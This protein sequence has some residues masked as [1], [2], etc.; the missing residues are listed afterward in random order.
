VL[1]Q[2]HSA[3]KYS[4]QILFVVHSQ[5]LDLKEGHS[6]VFSGTRSRKTVTPKS[7]K[8]EG[9]LFQEAVKSFAAIQVIRILIF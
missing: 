2:I 4:V 7:R 9:G 5:R 8:R 3:I 1:I 6:N